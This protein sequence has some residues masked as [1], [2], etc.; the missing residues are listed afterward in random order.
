MSE[1]ICI[2]YSWYSV[3]RFISPTAENMICVDGALRLPY[4]IDVVNDS[5]CRCGEGSGV[6]LYSSRGLCDFEY[7]DPI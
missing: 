1:N 6:R 3:D 4:R 7:A 5:K 2:F